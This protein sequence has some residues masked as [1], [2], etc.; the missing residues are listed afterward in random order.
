MSDTEEYNYY[1][2]IAVVGVGMLTKF[3]TNAAPPRVGE[4]MSLNKISTLDGYH[5]VLEVRHIYIAD[6][7]ESPSCFA[8]VEILLDEDISLGIDWRSG[9]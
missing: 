9:K 5:K 6:D 8:M 7:S 1:F 3:F 2:E 4:L